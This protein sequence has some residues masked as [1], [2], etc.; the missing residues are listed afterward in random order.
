MAMLTWIPEV[1]R[2]A[3]L[4]VVEYDG[5]RTRTTRASGLT[6]EGVVCHHTATGP[7]VSNTA[8]ARLLAVGRSDLRG[9][10][11]QLGLDRDGHFWMIAAGRCNHNGYGTWGNNSIGIEAYNDGRGEAWPAVQIDAYER[12][13]AA[14][15][16]HLNFPIARCRGH[17]ET[18]PGRKIDP[19]GIDMT[20]FR[21]R[22]AEH[23]EDDDM[24]VDLTPILNR[25]DE[26]EAKLDAVY[27][28]IVPTETVR[29]DIRLTRDIATKVGVTTSPP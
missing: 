6:V 29:A 25:L 15:L 10:L 16:A 13:C 9:P 20:A 4:V 3:G 17:K 23:M 24:A 8:V 21:A 19:R 5:W 28:K 7:N 18:D 27:D 12:G 14:L 11:A 26:I 22:V 2:D 1:L